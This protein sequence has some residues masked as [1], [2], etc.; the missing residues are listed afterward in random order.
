MKL[1][2]EFHYHLQFLEN[3]GNNMI[4]DK[5]SNNFLFFVQNEYQNLYWIAL[6]IFL[7]AFVCKALYNKSE[8]CNCASCPSTFIQVEVYHN[9]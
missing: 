1:E 8:S 5:T 3:M 4:M 9:E 6:F 2:L 7:C